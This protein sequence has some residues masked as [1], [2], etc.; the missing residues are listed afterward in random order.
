MLEEGLIMELFFNIVKSSITCADLAPFM[1]IINYLMN[2]VKF[3]VPVV[4]I[5]LIV[6]DFLKAVTTNDEKKMREAKNIALKRIFYA[7]I[8][9]LVPTIVSII[10][11]GLG[12]TI[13]GDELTTATEWISCFNRFN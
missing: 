8:L 11:R 1:R 3:I 2:I 13:S 12:G 5:V 6:V 4:L 9:F 10:F 7:I